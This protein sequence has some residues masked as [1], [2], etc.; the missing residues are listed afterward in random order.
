MDITEHLMDK[1]EV[2]KK[3]NTNPDTGL[4][5][6]QI[7]V[8]QEKYGLNQLTPPKKTPGWVKF[9]LILTEG[10]SLLLWAGGIM[11]FVAYAIDKSENPEEATDDNLWLGIVLVGVVVIT[12]VFTYYQEAKSDAVMEGFKKM[13]PQKA[14][15]VRNGEVSSIDSKFIVPGDVVFVE[16]GDR[17]P[18]DILLL[19]ASSFK[20]DNSS[21]TGESEPVTKTPECTDEGVFE[22]QNL[23]FFSTNAVE[24]TCKA[25]VIRTGDVTA[26]GHIAGLATSTESGDTPIR[27]EIRHFIKIIS[28]IAIF[29][30][31]TFGILSI[32]I[33][34]SF[35]EAVVFLIGIIVANVPEGLLATVTVALTLTAKKMAKKNCL[36]KNIEAVETLGS[37]SVICSD[38]TGTLTQNKMT[39]MH[40]WFNLQT[41]KLDNTERE[42]AKGFDEK[43]PGWEELCY[44]AALCSKAEFAAEQQDKI[45]PEK[46]VHG[47]ATEAGILKMTSAIMGGPEEIDKIRKQ[48]PRVGEIPFNSSNKYH[49][50]IHEDREGVNRV[51]MKGAPEKIFDHCTTYL[52]NGEDKK[53]DNDF[54]KKFDNIYEELGGMGER[55]LGFCDNKLSTSKFPSGF[56]FDTD[57]VNFPMEDNRFLGLVALVDPPKSSVPDAVG[58]CRSAGIRV[59]MVTGDHPVTAKAIAKHVNIISEDSKTV[60]DL[61]KEKGVPESEVD[62]TQCRARVISGKELA[63]MSE[64]QLDNILVHHPEIVFART[65]PEQKLTIVE[66]NQRAGSIVGVTGDGVNDSPALKK[67]DIGIAMGI[68]GSDVSKEAADMILLDDNFASIVLGV[69]EGRLIF[70]NLKKSIAYTLTSNI[71]EISPFLA[72]ITT[73][74]PLPL[75]TITILFIDLGTDMVPAISLAYEYPE[76]D[77]M[78]REP[79]DPIKDRLV[80]SRLIFLAY[81]LIGII[82]AT[83]GFFLYFLIMAEHGFFPRDLIGI[84]ADWEN[85]D[86]ND[87]TDSY[88]QEWSYEQRKKLEF[89][90][91][92][93]FFMAIVQVQWAYVIIS[94]TRKLSIF[95]QG[96]RNKF[97]NFG[98]CFE[99]CLAVFL[100]YT[101]GLEKA[102]RLYA[103]QP[104]YWLPALPFS[105]YIWVFDELRRALIRRNP[106]GFVSSIT[107]Y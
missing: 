62:V 77:I 86:I 76:R 12:A 32:A 16:K 103:L 89:S 74:I 48:N 98:L 35:V 69:E 36:V 105:L 24:G 106:D 67:A 65:T 80:N 31:V 40:W 34:Y 85:R 25:L 41:H 83:S 11:C 45:I 13:V 70:D 59:M 7:K 6:K 21:L 15:V 82:Q 60:D 3:Y 19:E 71:P 84:R 47:D 43:A 64:D 90:C 4:Q 37:T 18:A 20:V 46:E 92:T 94:K 107:Y 27:K 78:D 56:K 52:H 95:E 38:K 97:L 87:I 53:I 101:P 49:L 102:L 58:K 66:A 2:F 5:G 72:F 63:D 29:L 79:R 9:L 99:T 96:M 14:T 75:G 100:I 28:A 81:G 23:A 68:A 61:V 51:L 42:Y 22:T 30:G 54:R 39:V 93:A 55:V 88:G 1:E 8:L 17:V 10:F 104:E 73:G 44:A 26:V 50:S 33:G 91:H 57:D